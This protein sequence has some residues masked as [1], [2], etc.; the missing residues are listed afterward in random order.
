MECSAFDITKKLT[1]FILV[2]VCFLSAAACSGNNIGKIS[3]AENQ[4]V[5]I[6][7]VKYVRDTDS[8]YSSADRGKYLGKVSNSK[9]TMRVYSVKGDT[10]GE[11]IYTLWDWEGAFYQKEDR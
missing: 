8:G 4:Y 6:D 10:E 5:T 7:E 11:Y 3:G 2:I 1:A 9:I